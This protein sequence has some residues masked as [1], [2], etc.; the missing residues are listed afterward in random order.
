MVL[1]RRPLRH[2]NTAQRGSV[3]YFFRLYA[4]LL[5]AEIRLLVL[6]LRAY[7]AF[8]RG[9]L[10]AHDLIAIPFLVK[11]F[12]YIGAGFGNIASKIAVGVFSIFVSHPAEKVAKQSKGTADDHKKLVAAVKQ[13]FVDTESSLPS[14]YVS[15]GRDRNWRRLP[16]SSRLPLTPPLP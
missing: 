16:G 3:L 9:W 8:L 10:L 15:E 5:Q 12:S 1:A 13:S 11:N 4:A 14:E 2:K 7:Q 6:Q